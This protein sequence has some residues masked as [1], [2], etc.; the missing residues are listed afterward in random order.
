MTPPEDEL[1]LLLRDPRVSNADVAEEYGVTARTVLRWRVRYGIPSTYTR[2]EPEH[3]TTARYTAGETRF[4]APAELDAAAA[5][6]CADLA[7]RVHHV[8]GLRDLSRTD[9]I[10]RDGVPVFLET[11]VAPGMTETSLVP[12]GI[13]ASEATFAEVCA[14]LVAVA[15][16]RGADAD[17][18]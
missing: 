9:L 10:V 2:P 11:N 3:G 18:A 7:L 8:L 4:I 16:A 15:R 6:A 13:E 5:Q 12:L 14:R 1:V 17:R